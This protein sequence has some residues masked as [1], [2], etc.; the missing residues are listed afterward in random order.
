[1]KKS[2]RSHD[3]LARWGGEEFMMLLPE[4]S[5][6]SAYTIAERLRKRIEDARFMYGSRTYELTM[7]FGIGIYDGSRSTDEIIIMADMALLEGK[8]SGKNCVV[9]H[10]ELWV[11]SQVEGEPAPS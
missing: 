3:S 10:S 2:L 1:M 11:S 9:Y 7:T 5:A 8:N 4:T 6:L